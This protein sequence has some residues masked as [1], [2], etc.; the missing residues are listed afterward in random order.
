MG[1]NG[2]VGEETKQKKLQTFHISAVGLVFFFPIISPRWEKRK[3]R[4]RRRGQKY[5]S[6]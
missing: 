2:E 4:R 6:K 5:L 1:R 3:G